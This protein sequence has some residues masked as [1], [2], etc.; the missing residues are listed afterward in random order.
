MHIKI[1]NISPR[2]PTGKIFARVDF[3]DDK[4]TP[5]NSGTVDVFIDHSDSYAAI[6]KAAIEAAL[7]FMKEA[8]SAEPVETIETL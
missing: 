8:L 2:D 1:A 5:H 6:R 4:K 7:A 3:W